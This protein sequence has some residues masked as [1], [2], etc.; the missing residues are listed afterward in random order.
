M[1]EIISCSESEWYKNNIDALGW[2]KDTYPVLNNF[3]LPLP[4]EFLK[5][6]YVSDMSDRNLPITEQFRDCYEF[7]FSYF[8]E[9]YKKPLQNK[10]QGKT[11]IQYMAD[12]FPGALKQSYDYLTFQKELGW[13]GTNVVE[14]L[15]TAIKFV[16]NPITLII[17]IIIAVYLFTKK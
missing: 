16:L 10:F 4:F 17:L 2:Y 9:N 3:N 15:G 5:K 7:V 6:F 1:S 11:W 13:I 14:P 12:A 8:L